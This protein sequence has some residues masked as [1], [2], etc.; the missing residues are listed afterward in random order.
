MDADCAA[1][2][3]ETVIALGIELRV[4]VDN[5]D[6]SPVTGRKFSY[7]PPSEIVPIGS[8]EEELLQVARAGRLMNSSPEAMTVPST[9]CLSRFITGPAIAM[10]AVV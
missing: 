8:S 7:E 3:G 4:E 5:V 2:I 9:I 6:Q 10:R 1:E